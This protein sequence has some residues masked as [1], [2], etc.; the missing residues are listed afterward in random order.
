MMST[1]S[2]LENKERC[3]Q[4]I[5]SYSQTQE[6]ERIKEMVA[7]LPWLREH[8]GTSNCPL[9]EGI[10]EH[11]TEKD[12]ETAVETDFKDSSY[13][14]QARYIQEKWPEISIGLEKLK[15]IQDFVTF[16]TYSLILTRYG[17]GGSYDPTKGE[18]LI[19]IETQKSKE[20]MIG[21]IAHEIIHIGIQH[22]VELHTVTHWRKERSVD[23]I[24]EKYFPGM[25]KMQDIKEDVSMVD[26]AFT[27]LF[28]D[29]GAIMKLLA[30]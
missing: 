29:M 22:L 21:T 25:R 10:G 6:I 12:I 20:R 19:N 28:P 7:K 11:S 17:T 18:V 13:T 8:Y 30:K 2:H 9:P 16:D 5:I 24:T 15:A 4:L 26:V 1:E 14:E 23:L 3:A 27:D